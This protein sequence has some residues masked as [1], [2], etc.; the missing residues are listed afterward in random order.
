MFIFEIP[1]YLN[2]TVW[3]DFFAIILKF[4]CNIDEITRTKSNGNRQFQ[5]KIVNLFVDL[6]LQ[7]WVLAFEMK[8][9]RIF[10]HSLSTQSSCQYRGQ[11]ENPVIC[12]ADWFSY[13]SCVTHV[14]NLNISGAELNISQIPKRSNK[15]MRHSTLHEDICVSWLHIV[16]E[17][18]WWYTNE[19]SLWTTRRVF[20]RLRRRSRP[21]TA[22]VLMNSC[23]AETL[24]IAMKYFSKFTR[25]I[26]RIEL[27][28]ETLSDERLAIVSRFDLNDVNIFLSYENKAKKSFFI[29]GVSWIKK[30]LQRWYK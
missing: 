13:L 14:G 24:W 3:N 1:K 17:Y 7:L 19:I 26:Y 10:F 6:K 30:L 21:S 25:I 20:R 22:E 9:F 4:E 23:S 8:T 16:N 28:M 29:Q 5:E 12:L 15:V 18:W 27:C 2:K 11:V